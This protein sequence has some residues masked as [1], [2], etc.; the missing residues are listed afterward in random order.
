MYSSYHNGQTF[1]TIDPY[2]DTGINDGKQHTWDE[3]VNPP[4]GYKFKIGRASCRERVK[5]LAFAGE[6]NVEPD[7]LGNNSKITLKADSTPGKS[8]TCTYKNEIE[9]ISVHLKK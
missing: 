2:A 8:Y 4:A 3:Q 5:M 6:L 7:G 1:S 9:D